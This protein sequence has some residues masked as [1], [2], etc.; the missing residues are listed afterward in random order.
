M[1]LMRGDYFDN[2]MFLTMSFMEG[3]NAVRFFK[4]KLPVVTYKF[5]HKVWAKVCA[6]ILLITEVT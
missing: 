2:V 5:K 4:G 3:L 1:A 6:T